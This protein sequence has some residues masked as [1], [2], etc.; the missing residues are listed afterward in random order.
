MT[1]CLLKNYKALSVT[2]RFVLIA[3]TVVLVVPA[4]DT[5]TPEEP[6][7]LDSVMII[8][9][10][11]L[12]SDAFDSGRLAGSYD[13]VS[14][15]EL[16]YEHPDDTFELFSKVPGV[17]ISR[18][19]QGVINTDISIRGFAGDGV[20]PHAKLLIDGTPAN[21]HNGYNELDQMFPMAIGGIETFK[22]TGDLRYGLFNTAGNYNITSRADEAKE[23]QLTYGSYDTVE[24]QGYAGFKDGDL[25]HNYFAGY[26]ES[27]GYRDHTDLTKYSLSGRWFYDADDS[28]T[29]GLITR[30]SDYEGDS[31]GYLDKETARQNPQSSASFASEDG[32]EK[33]IGHVSLHAEKTF[34][35][36]SLFAT[37]YY[38]DIERE[39]FVRFSESGSLTDRFDD[40]EMSGLVLSGE[41]S[42][43]PTWDIVAGLDYEEQDVIEQRFGT[44]G[45][46]RVRDTAAVSRDR[47]YTLDVL[48]G[49]V[50]V[51]NQP[52]DRLEWNAGVRFD[53]LDGDFNS[54]DADGVATPRD[55]FDFGL[56]T[57][58]KANVIV[59][60]NEK[61][62]V[63]ANAGRSF[64]HP[65]GAG[66]F[67]ADDT[68]S[69]DVSINDGWEAGVILKP[70]EATKL[71]LSYWQQL[72]KDEFVN[73]DGTSRNVGET[74]RS[75][76]DATA[77]WSAS[78]Q[79]KVW[80][81][82]AFNFGEIK[83]AG[84]DF[85]GTS[86]NDLRSIPSHTFSVGLS[87]EIM[88][89][90]SARLHVDGQGSYYVNENNL[91][92]TFG[93]YTLLNGGV[94]YE[95]GPGTLSLQL[96]N[97]TDEFYEYVFDFGNDGAATIHSPGDGFNASLSYRLSL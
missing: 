96:N 43:A 6:F 34:G 42:V 19:N 63:F 1:H 23:L 28:L 41:W 9:S 82:V 36:G 59:S 13:F 57:Q 94:D 46:S 54:F 75:G 88:P 4:Q 5:G 62:A 25:T 91:G 53:E 48:G 70:L 61:T 33:S 30:Y 44:V 16:E 66:L 58:P 29:L 40:Q 77:D 72:A 45:Q 68:S 24:A 27:N 14:R 31:P 3:L 95:V 83:D 69:R 15:D 67:T 76:I 85:P 90:L 80:G 51:R 26:R 32:G 7:T 10:E 50:G 60:V 2:I 52:T 17:A 37:I 86:G 79:T 12:I 20:T 93:D 22:G 47:R 39:R 81:N 55:I 73:I 78:D 8:G 35:R 65:I 87:Q 49:Y 84:T 21:L 89:K 71:R 56:I 74:D 64:Q 92:G 18:Y 11:D 38:N 97:I